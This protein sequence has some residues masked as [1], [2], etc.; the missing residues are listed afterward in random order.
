LVAL[1]PSA[2]VERLARLPPRRRLVAAL[3]RRLMRRSA[4]VSKL[5]SLSLSLYIFSQIGVKIMSWSKNDQDELDRLL[6]KRDADKL[7]QMKKAAI[8]A[9]QQLAN[10]P[11]IAKPKPVLSPVD[12]LEQLQREQE[13]MKKAAILAQ[14]Q[15][16]NLSFYKKP[17]PFKPFGM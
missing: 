6:K 1:C 2:A 17:P 11:V 10:L 5:I 12:S 14:Q 3:P 8:L 4:V 16:A 15:S 7:E 13:Q 9:Q